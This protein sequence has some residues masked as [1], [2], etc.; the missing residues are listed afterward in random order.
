MSEL[1][2]HIFI[3]SKDYQRNEV[4]KKIGS[5]ASIVGMFCNILLFVVKIVLGLLSNS[6]AIISDAFNNLS[7][8]A[9]NIITLFGYKMAA[10]PA[11]KD[12][13]FGHGRIEYLTS[14]IIAVMILLVGFEL[15]KNS[16]IKIFDPQ[17]AV[18]SW[19]V[20]ISLILS[21]LLKFWMALFYKKM[22]KYIHS[23]VMNTTSQ[24][25]LNDCIVTGANIV[26]LIVGMYTNLPI[27]G[28]AGCVVSLFI[29]YSGYD[30]IRQTV[31]ELVGKSSDP[32]T[33][34]SIEK[35]ILSNDGILGL[36]DLVI[37][38]Y[39]PGKQMGS[40]HVEV[41]STCNF[42]EAH[43]VIDKIEREIYEQLRIMLTLH[44]DPVELNNEE[45]NYCRQKVQCIVTTIH[46]EM[47][48]HDFRVITYPTHKN[49]IFDLVVPYELKMMDH[50]IKGEI[51]KQLDQEEAKYSILVTLD[52]GFV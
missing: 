12:H 3:K 26:A 1:L 19:I 49:L 29:L 52:R 15:L 44:M 41:D 13:P 17:P 47:T 50:E 21:V 37:H 18:F 33:M 42:M 25:S 22:G 4:R 43:D 9:S 31:D 30:I 27:D 14:L 40:A 45:V 7:D 28:I 32:K 16:V 24:D 48:I 51:Q 10:K 46:A 11:D 36:H 38:D 2:C 5:M 20:L 39:G 35:H 23:V 6:I 34:E 8:S